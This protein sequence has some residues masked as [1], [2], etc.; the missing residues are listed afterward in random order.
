MEEGHVKFHKSV[1]E[2][3][4]QTGEVKLNKVMAVLMDPYYDPVMQ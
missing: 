2:L 1:S 3:Q 4:Q